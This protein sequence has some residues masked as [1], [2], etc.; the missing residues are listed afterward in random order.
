MPKDD[1]KLTLA[2]DIAGL[3]PTDHKEA[4]AVLSLV[5]DM[6]D[7]VNKPHSAKPRRQPRKAAGK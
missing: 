4:L 6:V 3:L 1:W 7:K 5:L 2:Y